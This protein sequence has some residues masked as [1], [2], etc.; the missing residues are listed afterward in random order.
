[1]LLKQNPAKILW[2]ERTRKKERIQFVN[3]EHWTRNFYTTRVF[4]N[5]GNGKKCSMFVNSLKA[6]PTKWSNKNCLSVF[7]HFVGLALK[8]I[9]KVSQLISTK[10]KEE[11]V[12]VTYGI[13]CR[14]SYTILRSFL[15]CIRG[16]RKPRNMK[17]RMRYRLML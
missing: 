13:R 14:T 9:K 12:M 8:G 1:M 2:N 3:F 4:S 16:S 6:N 5:R 11:S 17:N 7:H 10:Q 15:L